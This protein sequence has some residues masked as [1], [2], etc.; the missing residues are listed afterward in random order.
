MEIVIQHPPLTLPLI[1]SQSCYVLQ[2]KV[3]QKCPFS[4]RRH[5]PL[6]LFSIFF[7]LFVIFFNRLWNMLQS[8]PNFR[9]YIY[10][11][12]FFCFFL[13][14]NIFLLLTKPLCLCFCICVS[15]FVYLCICDS[16]ILCICV[17]VTAVVQIAFCSAVHRV[18]RLA[19][20]LTIRS[21]SVVTASNF[22]NGNFQT[23]TGW[24]RKDSLSL[25][26]TKKG[27]LT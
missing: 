16:Y 23:D 26:K 2:L 7:G 1:T 14:S 15:V 10:F 25:N 19:A 24:I 9:F 5:H 11:F 17:F 21:H 22:Q 6:S 4:L 12:L 13:V 27:S 3:S 18:Q 8:Q 20:S